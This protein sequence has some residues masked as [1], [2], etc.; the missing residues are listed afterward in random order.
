MLNALISRTDATQDVETLLGRALEV[1][2]AALAAQRAAVYLGEGKLW[3]LRAQRGWESAALS[4]L[5]QLPEETFRP[6]CGPM[7]T[8][9]NLAQA[10]PAC[11]TLF[12]LPL[13][14][15]ERTIG[16]ILVELHAP[17]PPFWAERDFL[18]ALG[19][20]IGLAVEHAYLYRR[21]EQRLRESQA[22]YE[23]G[24]A[25]TSTLDLDTLLNLI[26]RSA[27][28]T[29]GKAKN[30][31]LHLLDEETNELRPKALSFATPGLPDM[32]GR[33]RMKPGQGVAGIALQLGQVVNVPDVAKD[34]RFI[35][36]GQ[37]RSFAAMLVAP[38][39]VGERRIGTLSIDSDEPFA[40]TPDDE[41]LLMTLASQAAT[42]I[43]QARLVQ[44]LQQSLEELRTTQAQLIQSEKLSAIG[45]LIAGVAHEL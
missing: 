33:S 6:C 41:R 36:V 15:R 10:F 44:D 34:E 2:L 24:R 43:E 27:V 1:I 29:I 4:A 16:V 8:P 23:V 5:G 39:L 12:C 32:V 28:D 19:K 21:M 7:Q 42:A 22:L 26:V 17:L 38:L 20:T 11:P 35:R 30:G 13:L 14:V 25:L 40:F 18:D 37:G 3:V 45:Q 9:P 31:V